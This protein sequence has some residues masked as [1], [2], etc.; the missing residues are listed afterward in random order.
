[1]ADRLVVFVASSNQQ[2]LAHRLDCSFQSLYRLY[3]SRNVE[4]WQV[5]PNDENTCAFIQYE[6]LKTE[7]I[8][9]I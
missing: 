5:L 6:P 4:S 9:S 3:I 2:Y 7:D 1:M 8:I